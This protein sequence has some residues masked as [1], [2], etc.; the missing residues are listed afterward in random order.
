MKELKIKTHFLMVSEVF[1]AYHPKKGK[2][3]SFRYMINEALMPDLN[4]LIIGKKLHTLRE[5]YTYWEKI[6]NEVL[7]GEA[8]LSLRV[9]A[10]KPYYSSHIEFKQLDSSSGLGIQKLEHPD[11]FVYATIDGKKY[12]WAD[13]ANNDGLNFL[14]FCDWFKVR[15]PDPMAVIHFTKFRY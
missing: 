5:N 1:P 2:S 4:S 3:T 12:D 14:D 6:I 8:V 15:K 7:A 10:G 13:V 9:W 11:N